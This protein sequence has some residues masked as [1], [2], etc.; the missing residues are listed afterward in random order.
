MLESYMPALGNGLPLLRF[1]VSSVSQAFIS[2]L[3]VGPRLSAE[4]RPMAR[5]HF[6]FYN[7]YG[8][9]RS[10]Y[11]EKLVSHRFRIQPLKVPLLPRADLRLGSYVF[12][13]GNINAKHAGGVTFQTGQL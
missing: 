8:P 7:P 2:G 9:H 6:G 5:R 12:A 4:R 13:K 10:T 11:A 3:R 1:L